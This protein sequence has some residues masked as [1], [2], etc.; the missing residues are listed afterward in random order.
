MLYLS[1]IIL[2]LFL[3]LVLI[4]KRNKTSADYLLASWLG[5]IGFHLLAFYL[6]FTNQQ[7]DYPS[8]VV[9]GFS[10]PL[11]HGPFLN[12]YTR[13]QTS[14][15]PF[16]KKQLLISYRFFYPLSCL[17]GFIFCHQI[18]KLNYS[19]KKGRPFKHK[20]RSIYMLSMFPG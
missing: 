20:L 2:S 18:R 13:Q 16:N 7:L 10:L 6:F 1:A 12:L 11:V 4:S 8:V 15:K 9:P 14:D 5:S 17:Q 19:G 3:A